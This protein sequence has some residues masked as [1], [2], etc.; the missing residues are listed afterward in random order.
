MVNRR[1]WLL[2]LLGLALIGGAVLIGTSAYNYGVAQGV[3]HATQISGSGSG[4]G[5]W[6]G[7]HLWYGGPIGWAPL[8][9]GFAFFGLLR[10]VPFVGLIVLVVRW[11]SHAGRGRWRDWSEADRQSFEERHRHA[12]QAT[13][14]GSTT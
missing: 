1:T 2:V 3:A 6:A 11:L 9:L 10:I 14:G 7:P 13:D 4:V 8:G 12:H 5:P